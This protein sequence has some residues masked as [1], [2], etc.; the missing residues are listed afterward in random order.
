MDI[1]PTMV[2]ATSMTTTVETSRPGVP[3][4]VVVLL[5]AVMSI[6]TILQMADETMTFDAGATRLLIALAVAWLLTNLVYAVVD[7]MRPDVGAVDVTV[8]T[9]TEP[10]DYPADYSQAPTAPYQPP[11]GEGD[12]EL[13]ATGT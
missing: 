8:E 2:A 3:F 4:G 5:A 13:K 1:P 11:P 7:G 12:P 10:V 9:A 6:S